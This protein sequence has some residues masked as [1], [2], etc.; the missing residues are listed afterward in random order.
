N[1]RRDD[2][3]ERDGEV[4]SR[5]GVVRTHTM[6]DVP[7]FARPLAPA[8][9]EQ[10]LRAHYDPYYATLDRLLD[11]LLA[12][13]GFAI[14]LDGPT[15]SP[16]RMQGHQVIIGA[17]HGS[18]CSPALTEAVRAVFTRHGFEVHENVSG[19]TGGNIVATA[20]QPATRQ[21]HALQIEINSALLVTVTW[22][23]LI[24]LISRGEGPERAQANLARGAGWRNQGV[25][26]L[27]PGLPGDRR[28]V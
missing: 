9:L 18:T 5:R 11:E 20:G 10:R 27:P 7:L 6:R 17:R 1:R 23:E 4:R 12:Q 13:H 22:E 28:A 15:G 26:R 3:E 16:R 21:V 25:R 2:F 14:L 19:Y 8:D 24:A